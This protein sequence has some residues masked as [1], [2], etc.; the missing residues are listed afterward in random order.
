MSVSWRPAALL[1]AGIIPLVIVQQRYVAGLWLVFVLVMCV[2]DYATAAS[3]R[4]LSMRR[5]RSSAVHAGEPSTTSLTIMNAGKRDMRADVR[6]A[7]QPSAGAH[8]HIFSTRI[9]AGESVEHTSDLEPTRRGRL[10][11]DRVTVRSWGRMRLVARQLSF[12]C[13]GE[14]DSL[15]AFPSKAK[16]PVAFAKLRAVE[17][18]ATARIRGQG[19]EFDSLREWV[20]GDDVRSID[21]RA[22]ARTDDELIVRTWRPERDRHVVMLLDTSRV[23]AARIADTPRLDTA[24]DATLLLSAVC[25]R[26]GDHISMIAGSN[27]VE[28]QVVRPANADALNDVSHALMHVDPQMIEANWA[29]LAAAVHGLG[30]KVSLIVIFTSIDPTVLADA[31]LP[32]LS[33]LANKHRVMIA[34]VADSEDGI[35]NLPTGEAETTAA[36]V[37]RAAAYETLRE[38]SRQAIT[39]LEAMGVSVVE[40]DAENLPMAVVDHYLALKARGLL[41]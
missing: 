7:W 12:E 9:R 40:R 8:N 31:L 10:R 6:D 29:R 30:N 13:P 27:E 34:S 21:W 17:G 4:K 25:A 23:M 24:M 22:T 36:D 2:L 35:L 38:R 41:S 39:G 11:T 18:M 20:D 3:P 26:A 19:T 14:L 32:Q 28:Q 33:V 37:Y 15:P 5:E 1:L 16:L